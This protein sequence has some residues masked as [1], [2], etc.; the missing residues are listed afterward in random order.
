[1]PE[2]C[3]PLRTPVRKQ[4]R[5]S[6]VRKGDQAIGVSESRRPLT[7]PEKCEV[8]FVRIGQDH[9]FG[10]TPCLAATGEC[11]LRIQCEFAPTCVMAQDTYRIVVVCR[12]LLREK[13]SCRCCG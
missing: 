5:T 10:I 12:T 1:T 11:P 4:H 9:L 3:A 7:I 6:N 2:P 8:E 13:D